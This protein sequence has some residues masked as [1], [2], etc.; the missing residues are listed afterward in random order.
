MWCWPRER[1]LEPLLA[2]VVKPAF[3]LFT[4][5]PE[6][7][8]TETSGDADRRTV[9]VRTAIVGQREGGTAQGG[10]AQCTSDGPG[11]G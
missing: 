11:N 8:A 6:L 2:E 9:V 3:G 7:L 10:Q 5:G 1:Y 4:E